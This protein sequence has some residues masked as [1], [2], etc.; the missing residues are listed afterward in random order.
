[1]VRDTAQNLLTVKKS[2]IYQTQ[3]VSFDKGLL[4][5]EK[6]S[7]TSLPLSCLLDTSFQALKSFA[8]KARAILEDVTNDEQDE[9]TSG[10]SRNATVQE[11]NGEERIVE[12]SCK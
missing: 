1:E 6:L 10:G 11:T 9:E 8:T 2:G 4:T 5:L 12:T 7:V 3:W